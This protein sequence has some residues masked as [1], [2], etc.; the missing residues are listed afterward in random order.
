VFLR[1]T[2]HIDSFLVVVML[3]NYY[4]PLLLLPHVLI[5]VKQ[6]FSDFDILLEV[7]S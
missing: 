4:F 1:H 6:R 7:C 3:V 5:L 2:I